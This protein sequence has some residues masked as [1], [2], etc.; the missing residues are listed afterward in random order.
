MF[1]SRMPG[2]HYARAGHFVSFLIEEFGAPATAAFVAQSRSITP[3]SLSVD[4]E[5][6]F[7][8]S[9]ERVARA[10]SEEP[11]SCTGS[12]WQRFSACEQEPTQWHRPLTWEVDV[13]ATC[14]SELPLGAVGGSVRERFVYETV[15]DVVVSVGGFP[16]AGSLPTVALT[17]CGGGCDEEFSYTHDL[18]EG[19]RLFGLPLDAGT[20]LVTATFESD[21]EVEPS[22]LVISRGL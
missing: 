2:V 3:E 17:R 6:H 1:D 11:E 9:L 5:A 13:G 19:G 15:D 7:G 10:Y 16:S 8:E 22:T 12:G 14:E 21:D 18:E 4:F 20:Y